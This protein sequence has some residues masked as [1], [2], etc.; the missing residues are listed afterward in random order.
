MSQPTVVHAS[1]TIDRVYPATPARVFAAWASA[2][3]KGRWFA[4]PNGWTQVRRELDFRVGG[5]EHV[6]GRFGNGETTAFDATYY[7]IVP[8]QRII[9]VYDM[10]HNDVHLS[11]SLATIEFKPEGKGTRLTIT[12][13][14]AFLNG[15]DN[16]AQ[17]EAGTQE[18]LNTLGRSLPD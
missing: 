17:R 2:E 15:Y 13:Q 12:E 8:E 3:A 6:H 5:Q 7:D 18:L 16:V 4:G 1:F 9:Y 10:R 11:I 14:G